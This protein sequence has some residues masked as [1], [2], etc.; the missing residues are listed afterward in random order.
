MLELNMVEEAKSLLKDVA[1]SRSF[2]WTTGLVK[3]EAIE[4]LNNI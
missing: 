3:K 4:K 1:D 2:G